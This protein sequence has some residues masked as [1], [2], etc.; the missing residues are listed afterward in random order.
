MFNKNFKVF[1]KKKPEGWDSFL[2]HSDLK[3]TFLQTSARAEFLMKVYHAKPIYCMI[4]DDEGMV[5]S[6]F[7]IIHRSNYSLERR[8][9]FNDYKTILSGNLNGWLEIFGAP[10]FLDK[11]IEEDVKVYL[12]FMMQYCN[13]NKVKHMEYFPNYT[14][15][16]AEA[17]L[18]MHQQLVFRGFD[19]L[20]W[21]S[22]L[23]DL[24]LEEDELLKKMNKST[25]K[26]L[27]KYNR[28]DLKI[29]EC[30]DDEINSIFY[31]S[32]IE[33][34]A[35]FGRSAPNKVIF[36]ELKSLS[37]KHYH[38]FVCEMDGIG[39]IG[40]LG[41]YC[42]NGIVV[43]I[44]SSSSEYTFE[45]N[46]PVQDLLHWHIIRHQKSKGYVLYDLAGFNP[47]PENKKEEGIRRFKEKW[48]GK[49]VRFNRYQWYSPL[50]RFLMQIKKMS[51]SSNP[52]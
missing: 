45:N 6:V 34:E 35:S 42:H 16:N 49:E 9:V 13:K 47:N 15:V 44:A 27:R 32:Y 11:V 36:E 10:V 21:A 7:L 22:S 20:P 38:F 18:L 50:F 8:E 25:R 48:G 43:E 33:I 39:V 52:S 37:P 12:D 31:K 1:Y 51:Q 26:N 28:N 5:T 41:V 2:A 3:S 46:I 4:E 40:T 14:F 19:Y 23:I 29:H 30:V 24:S 17:H